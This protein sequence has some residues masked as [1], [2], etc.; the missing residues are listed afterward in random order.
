M[1]DR[2][3][4]GAFASSSADTPR[5]VVVADDSP[6]EAPAILFL[7]HDLRSGGAE[8]V[9][10]NYVNHLQRFRPVAA[11]VR[12]VEEI[13]DELSPTVPL[14]DL[15]RPIEG[16]VDRRAQSEWSGVAGQP[17][18][19]SGTGAPWLAPLA[20]LIK[21]HR[22]ASLAV[23]TEAAVVCAFLHKSNIIALTAKLLLR[24]G[25]RV[26]ISMHEMPAPY[27]KFH[28]PPLRRAVMRWFTRHVLPRADLIVAVSDG[29][30]Q[31]LTEEFGISARRIVVVHNPI[32]TESIRR[33]AGE[34][35]IAPLAAGSPLIVAVG[36]LVRFKGFDLLVRAMAALPPELRAHLIIIGEGEERTALEALID[37]EGLRGSVQ[38]LGL[39][40]NPWQYMALAEVFVLSSRTE[41]LPNVIIEAFALGLPVVAADCSAGVRELLAGGA[42]GVLVEPESAGALAAGLERVLRDE[43]LRRRLAARGVER[44]AAFDLRERVRHF[45]DVLAAVA[46]GAPPAEAE[47]A[48]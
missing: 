16:P 12:P 8:R 6:R 22:L 41:A 9:F 23:R 21:A 43:G 47:H 13:L 14:Y 4:D 36:R 26:V 15:A 3:P 11:V 1:P 5:S 19:P 32:D 39:Q 42:D 31:N 18:D 2:P 20:L 17:T 38:L 7:I 34:P 37:A 33:F 10:L 46:Q 45:E 30:K 48:R 44:A 25:L 28:F 29:V 35:L 40:R 27:M 24:P